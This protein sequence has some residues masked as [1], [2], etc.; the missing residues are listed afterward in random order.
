MTVQ[1]KS[2]GTKQQKQKLEVSQSRPQWSVTDRLEQVK[3][4]MAG[5]LEGWL[6]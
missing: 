4:R 1:R 6:S 3:E 2:L 5:E